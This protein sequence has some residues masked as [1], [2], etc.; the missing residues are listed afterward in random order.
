MGDG[1]SVAVLGVGTIKIKAKIGTLWTDRTLS[2]VSYI[3]ELKTNLLSIAAISKKGIT[4]TF[5]GM[6][7]VMRNEN[8][9]IAIGKTMGD[10]LYI[11]DIVVDDG[12]TIQTM[13]VERERSSEEWHEV[14]GHPSTKCLDQTL[15][16]YG[17][18]KVDADEVDCKMCP[19]GKGIDTTHQASS[20]IGSDNPG[21][22]IHVDL[23]FI[24][25][26]GLTYDYYL[27]CKDEA[28]EFVLIYFLKTKCEINR[29]LARII[30]DVENGCGNRVK[31]VVSDNG[32]EFRNRANELL[33]LKEGIMQ[34]FSA[35]YTP[36]Q[37]GL[38][39]R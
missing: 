10:N 13:L 38:I 17:I 19:M 7:C 32:S 23:G 29:A 4:T 34:R 1:K 9:T 21:E 26:K 11:M 14:L 22:V 24:S 5:S 15:K 27:L 33:F 35:P 20:R 30:I 12:D 3:P 8:S 6:E 16:N 31:V 25:N 39:E 18:T 2:N 36:Q 37:N 28:S